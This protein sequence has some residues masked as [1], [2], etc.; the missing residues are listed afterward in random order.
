M[1]SALNGPIQPQIN[2]NDRVC[3]LSP[4]DQ[5]GVVDPIS[6]R[7]SLDV[8][9]G[10]IERLLEAAY[11]A[12]PLM[13]EEIRERVAE[14]LT[15]EAM[16]TLAAV[17][18]VWAGSHFLG[19]GVVLD[20]VLAGVT[21]V[22]VG[23][24]AIKALRGFARYYDCAVNARSN[25][26]MQAAARHFADAMITAASAIGWAR[27]GRWLASGP[28]V[29]IRVASAGR[30][31]RWRG[32]IANLKF[33]VPRDKGMLWSSLGDFRS[34][35]KLGNSKGLVTLESQLKKNG[36]YELYSREFG[37]V[38]DDV[39]KEIWTL[40]SKKYV[41]SLEGTVTGYVDRA[42]HFKKIY[43][44]ADPRLINPTDPVLVHEVDEISKILMS[45]PKITELVLIDIKSGEAFGY[46]SRELLESLLRLEK[47]TP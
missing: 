1:R 6:K 19:V 24:D 39:T 4:R 22:A 17:A 16:A 46:R 29:M 13:P 33:H 32:Y 15:P 14:L 23:W 31:A 43:K 26:D 8:P 30:L 41:N 28:K 36:F 44:A 42:T 45:N 20:V 27:L 7:K 5:P 9:E 10:D 11:R 35:E 47:A 25:E 37:K 38:Q 2:R 34:A 3:W 12:L 18:T 40:V 21:V